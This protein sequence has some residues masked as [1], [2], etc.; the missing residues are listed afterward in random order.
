MYN[1]YQ[2]VFTIT[3]TFDGSQGSQLFYGAAKSRMSEAARPARCCV[4]HRP[5]QPLPPD[6][7]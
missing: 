2:D 7:A 6:P 3:A 5:T 1:D 4:A